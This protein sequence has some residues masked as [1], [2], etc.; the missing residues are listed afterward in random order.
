MNLSS[1]PRVLPMTTSST[2]RHSLRTLLAASLVAGLVQGCG[3]GKPKINP[4][5]DEETGGKGGGS[6]GGKGGGSTGGKGGG[7]GGKGGGGNMG[8]EG[9]GAGGGNGGN[10]GGGAGMGGGGMGAGGMA[11]PASCMAPATDATAE[12][13]TFVNNQLASPSPP[14]TLTTANAPQIVVF[15]WDDV[16]NA[17][18]MA[19]VNQLI[20]GITNPDGTKGNTTLNPNACYAYSP[21]YLCGDGSLANS[22]DQVTVN[23]FDMGNHTIDHLESVS[24]WSGIPAKY[25]DPMT[26]SWAQTPDGAYGPGVLMDQPTWESI[27]RVNERE[28]KSLFGVTTLTGFR[29]PRLELNDAGLNALKTLNYYDQNLEEVLAEGHADAATKVDTAAKKGFNWVPWPYTLDH[30]SPGIWQQQWDGDKKWVVNYPTGVWEVPVYMLYV[31]A[32]NNLGK[33]IADNM[34]K[35]DAGCTFPPGTP[36]DQRKHCYLGEGELMA[37]DI[38]KEVTGFDFNTFIYG[39]FTKA[40]FLEVM[41]HTFL[42]RFYGN[43]AP[44]T[45][46]AHPIEYTAPYDNFTLGMQAN[47]YGYRDVLTYSKYTDRQA[48]MQEFV[49]WIKSDPVLSKETYFLSG[50]QLVDFMKA[51]FDKAGAK[52]PLDTV[53]TPAS[54]GVFTRLKW[55][56][57]HAT[58]TA[59]DGNSADVVFDVGPADGPP[60]GVS[61]GVTQG[62]LKGLSHIDIKYSSDVPFRVRLLTVDGETPSTTVLLAGTGTTDRVA[63]IRV[64]DFFLGPEAPSAVAQTATLVDANYMGKVNGIAIES[65]HTAIT[66]GMK[67]FTAHI[68]QLTLH[69]VATAALCQ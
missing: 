56:A 4:P 30:G 62:S 7:T 35:S 48:A 39:R 10:G 46:G 54:N 36:A 65:A 9:G 44:L 8:G 31:P 66:G 69:G 19:F 26:G 43:R 55:V 25:K 32:K 1:N 21:M 57:D 3:N 2:V 18:G 22:K 64:K 50:Q 51:P 49:Q 60:V 33:T 37:G 58:I 67:K 59:M 13:L 61:A 53:A 28:L 52:V 27:L 12:A 29:A 42:A 23:K 17:P 47:N 11:P 20:G 14:G 40:I 5:D 16:E 41:K 24:T 63:H 68:K 38:I 15:G 45:Y 34:L 6:T